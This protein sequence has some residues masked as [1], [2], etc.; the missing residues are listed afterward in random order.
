MGRQILSN[1]AKQVTLD[2]NCIIELE[3]NRSYAPY[4][5]QLITMHNAREIQLRIVAVGG[6]EHTVEGTYSD[7]FRDFLCRLVPIGLAGAEILKP[8]AYCG[9]AFCGQ[10]VVGGGEAS[11]L[12]TRIQEALFP[13]FN[14]DDPACITS[15]HLM[16]KLRNG[17][18]DVLTMWCHIWYGGGIFVTIDGNFHK[19]TKKPRLI[20]LGAGY[21][22]RPDEAVRAILFQETMQTSEAH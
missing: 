13:Q 15:D 8:L 6:A 16:A 12:E 14:F 3:D 18:C 19:A 20:D 22:L 10:F 2:H 5:Q 17:R 7:D 4:L 1:V 11:N 21:I 9:M